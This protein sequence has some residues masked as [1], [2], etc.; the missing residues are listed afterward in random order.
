MGN[1]EG[2]YDALNLCV[3]REDRVVLVSI[4]TFFDGK[5][6]VLMGSVFQGINI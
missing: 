2:W 5:V 4:Y 1:E 6:S 3:I